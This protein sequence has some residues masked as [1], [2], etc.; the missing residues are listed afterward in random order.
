MTS[1]GDL[2]MQY[3]SRFVDSASFQRPPKY[4]TVT[5]MLELLWPF[6]QQFKPDIEAIKDLPYQPALEKQADQAIEGFVNTGMW[7]AS[8]E[9]KRVLL[10]RHRQI[11]I[12]LTAQAKVEG[13]RKAL[14]VPD[15]LPEVALSGVVVLHLL[16][17][18]RLPA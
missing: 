8:L 5:D 7:L 17:Q 9:V 2:I 16:Y 4:L 14:P 13:E 1:K 6:N 15:S 12:M 18:A 11:I 3:M 10:E